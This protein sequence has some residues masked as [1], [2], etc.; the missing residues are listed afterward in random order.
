MERVGPNG[1]FL[2]MAVLFLA[3]AGYAA[4]RMTRRRVGIAGQT[5]SFAPLSP[6]A[7]V[8]AVEAAMEKTADAT[9]DAWFPNRSASCEAFPRLC[10]TG[11]GHV[12]T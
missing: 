8:I 3:L 2:V 12:G 6:V 1:Y 5:A 7:G 4:W 9:P 10:S 11:G